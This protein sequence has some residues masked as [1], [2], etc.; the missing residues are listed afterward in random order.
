MPCPGVPTRMESPSTAPPRGR[1][2]TRGQT[3]LSWRS[4]LA[5]AWLYQHSPSNRRMPRS[6]PNQTLLPSG[7]RVQ[8]TERALGLASP[9]RSSKVRTSSPRI[10]VTPEAALGS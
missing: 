4:R 7:A 9:S 8:A 6:V 3:P 2:M 10:R 5:I 1:P